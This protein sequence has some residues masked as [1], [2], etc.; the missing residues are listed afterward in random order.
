M[1]GVLTEVQNAV[2]SILQSDK[3]Y[4]RIDVVSE[5]L[6]DIVNKIDIALKKL[7]IC[8]V[9]HTAEATFADPDAP[10]PRMNP[11]LIDIDVTEFVLKNRGDS[12]SGLPADDVAEHTAWL[13]HYP[14]HAGTRTDP[15]ILTPKKLFVVPDKT[16]LIYRL[17][18][19]TTGSLA[20]ITT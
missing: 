7:G 14:N 5:Q 15:C 8:I 6:G 3:Y 19:E 20:G 10:G 18:V 12:G 9:V 2:V 4:A 1:S 16:F 13:L 17:Q 11:L